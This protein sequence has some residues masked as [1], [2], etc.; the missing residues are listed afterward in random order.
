MT[1]HHIDKQRI[2]NATVVRDKVQFNTIGAD[3]KLQIFT[4]WLKS[5][6]I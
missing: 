4:N 5:C 2:G 1:V 3:R 6:I